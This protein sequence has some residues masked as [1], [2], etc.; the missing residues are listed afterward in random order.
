M[1]V[2]VSDATE[3][4]HRLLLLPRLTDEDEFGVRSEDRPYPA[5]ET[6]VEAD[7]DRAPE[8]ARCEDLTVAGVEEGG[9]IGLGGEGFVDGVQVRNIEAN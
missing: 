9:A 7:E 3:A 2:V 1:D 6:S 8:K 5:R 4:D